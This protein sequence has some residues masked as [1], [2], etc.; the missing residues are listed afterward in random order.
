MNVSECVSVVLL[1]V[2]SITRRRG[3]A[4]NDD[5]G[6]LFVAFGVKN[7]AADASLY[8]SRTNCFYF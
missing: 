5:K 8:Q 6:V 3:A 4:V 7:A 1:L 2:T